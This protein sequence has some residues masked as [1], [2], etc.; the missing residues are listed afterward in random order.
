MRN[1]KRIGLFAGL[2]ALVGVLALGTVAFAQSSDDKTNWPF[3]F[4]QKLREAIAE[5]L[6]ISVDEYDAA[7]ETAQEKVL[8]QAVTD[9]WLTQEQADLLR[10]RMEQAPGPGLRGMMGKGF[11]RFGWGIG[12]WG[13]SLV[14]VAADKLDMSLTDLL[15]ELQ[16]GKSI[17]EVA[18]EKGVDPQTIADAYLAEYSENLSEAV[19]KGRIT[20]KQADWMLETM[21]EQ[22]TAQLESTCGGFRGLMPGGF[23]GFRGGGRGVPFGGFGPMGF[24]GRGRMAPD[25]SGGS[26]SSTANQ[27]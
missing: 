16:D 17:A 22:V 5:A 8:E 6:G 26:T 2:I 24:G 11:G 13:E 9:G 1:W 25:T 23:R 4:G 20:Q 3:D 7:V 19:E 14:S 27:L 12:P 18:K 10:W 21:K 15:T